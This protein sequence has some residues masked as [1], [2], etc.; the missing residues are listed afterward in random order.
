MY[1]YLIVNI[2]Y[3]HFILLSFFDFIFFLIIYFILISYIS[4]LTFMQVQ[5]QISLHFL[6][7]TVCVIKKL[8]DL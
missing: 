3:I 2:Q 1:I 8:F 5:K 7:I 6:C 4:S